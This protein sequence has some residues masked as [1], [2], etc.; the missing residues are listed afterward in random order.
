MADWQ[1]L[2]LGPMVT[3][4]LGTISFRVHLLTPEDRKT[5]GINQPFIFISL[6][7]SGIVI[8]STLFFFLD[9]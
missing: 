3:F 6:V 5:E 2:L 9:K 8:I 7:A 4:I 1:Y